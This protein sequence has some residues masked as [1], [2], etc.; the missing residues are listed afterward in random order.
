MQHIWGLIK[1][2][3]KHGTIL[4]LVDYHVVSCCL[5]LDSNGLSIC[6][7]HVINPIKVKEGC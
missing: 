1:L 4:K 3:T 5:A 2:A 7:L 6:I